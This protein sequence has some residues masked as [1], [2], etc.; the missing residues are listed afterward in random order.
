MKELFGFDVDGY[1][2]NDLCA[3]FLAHPFWRPQ[4][5]RTAMSHFNLENDIRSALRMDAPIT[6]GPQMRWQRKL[7]ESCNTSRQNESLVNC[8]LNA[9]TASK[10]P[11]KAANRSVVTKTPGK[12]PGSKAQNGLLKTPG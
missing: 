4:Q 5:N 9:S 10:T 6:R 12:T 2:N 8:S 3:F 7:N 1:Q 11:M